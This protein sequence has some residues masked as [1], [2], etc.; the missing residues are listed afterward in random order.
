MMVVSKSHFSGMLLQDAENFCLEVI[1]KEA[2]ID[3]RRTNDNGE[4]AL[5]GTRDDTTYIDPI[6]FIN[7]KCDDALVNPIL[8]GSC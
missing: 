4:F 7:H 2:L 1:D 5:D 8:S 3:D 6:L